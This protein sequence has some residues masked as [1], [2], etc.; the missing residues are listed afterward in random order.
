[1]RIED[2]SVVHGPATGPKPAYDARLE[3]DRLALRRRP[4]VAPATVE[5]ATAATLARDG[6]GN[7]QDN[8]ESKSSTVDTGALQ[9]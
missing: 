4:T 2:G 3:G 7:G 9:A 5:P 8:W 1:F 6:D